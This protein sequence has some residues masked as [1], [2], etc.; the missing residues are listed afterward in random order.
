[1]S[2]TEVRFRRD[3][4][5]KGVVFVVVLLIVLI[6][7]LDSLPLTFWIIAAVLVTMALIMVDRAYSPEPLILLND[8]GVFDR[9]LRLGIIRW[10]DIRRIKSYSVS[11]VYYISLELHDKKT[12]QA[13]RPSW[14][15]VWVTWWRPFGMSP[16]AINTTALDVDHDTLIEKLH[17]GCMEAALR[18]QIEAER[19]RQ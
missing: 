3:E 5:W 12:Y 13:R 7:I 19:S 11:G 18:I 4:V 15:R 1:M 17:E 6:F 9:R 14:L 16:I 10:E 2:P 8:E